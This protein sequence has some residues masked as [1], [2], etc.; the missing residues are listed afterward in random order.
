M[1]VW[2]FIK[3]ITVCKICIAEGNKQRKPFMRG[4]KQEGL[5]M[6]YKSMQII[7]KDSRLLSE[8]QET[9][10]EKMKGIALVI[11]IALHDIGLSC[12]SQDTAPLYRYWNSKTVDHFYTTDANEIGTTIP[13]RKGKHGYIYEGIQCHL[14]THQVESSVPLYRYWKRS[15]R[16]H[17]YTTNPEEI[18][19]TIRGQT[20]KHGYKSEGIVGYCMSCKTPKTVPLY[21]YWRSNRADHF[22][23]TNIKEIGT[24]E[25]GRNGRHGYKSEGITCYVLPG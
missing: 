8:Q 1:S 22:Y 4:L 10:F 7:T 21:R 13:N 25:P 5:Y 11:F 23:T 3:F 6:Y 14:Y 12:P 20:G 24:A 2:N 18:G 19:I 15:S 9:K 16:D 17:F